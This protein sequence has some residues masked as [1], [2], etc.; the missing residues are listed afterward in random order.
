[1]TYRRSLS[2][3]VILE[4]S[5]LHLAFGLRGGERIFVKALGGTIVLDVDASDTLN[6]AKAKLRDKNGIPPDQRR[7]ILAGKQLVDGRPL[8]T[9]T[10][11]PDA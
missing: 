9:T 1:M 10:R 5:T 8:R 2:V 4:E 6:T 7:V 11:Q 3:Y